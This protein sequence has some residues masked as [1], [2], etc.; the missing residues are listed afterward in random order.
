MT[1]KR[2]TKP[3]PMSVELLQATA[4]F[5]DAT[6]TSAIM[7]LGIWV[8]PIPM[9]TTSLRLPTDVIARLREQAAHRNVRYT[10]YVR[11]LLEQASKD[12]PTELSEI[13]KRLD[14]IEAVLAKPSPKK[15]A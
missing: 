6:D 9:T 10:S 7:E 13:T 1:K 15:A 14:R 5:Y 4:D 2:V 3:L 12:Q 11:S 8:N